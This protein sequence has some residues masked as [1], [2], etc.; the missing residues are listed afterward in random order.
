MN[1][2]ARDLNAAISG[3]GTIKAQELQAENGKI[4]IAGSGTCYV[5]VNDRLNVS[6][7]GS[8]DVRYKGSPSVKSSVAGSGNISKMR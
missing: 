1:G 2:A 8:G 3:S 7:A 4:S 5:N 6:I